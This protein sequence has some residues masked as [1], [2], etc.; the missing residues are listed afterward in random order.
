MD[1]ILQE[2]NA[3]HASKNTVYHCLYGYYFLGLKRNH[4]ARIYKKHPTTIAGWIKKYEQE[5][6]FDRKE[7]SRVFKR[8]GV[9]ER[10]WIIELYNKRPVLLLDEARDLFQREFKKTI[11]AASINRILHDEGYSWKVLERRAIQLRFSDIQR[12]FNELSSIVWDLHALVFL[13]EVS[14]DNRGML[15][16]KGYAPVGKKLIYRGEFVRRPRCSLLSFLGYDGVLETF[17]TEGTFT[18]AKFFDCIRKF[19]TNGSVQT[20][21]GKYSVWIMDGARIHCH[22]SIIDYL[23]SLGIIVLFLPAYAPFYNPIEYVFGYLKKYLKRNYVENDKTDLS[24]IIARA[25]IR[26]KSYDCIRIFR[27]C[28]YLAGGQFD[29][30]IGLNQE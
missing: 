22:K 10:Q 13:D 15:R 5:G 8:F 14:F 12:F 1:T 29:P 9:A 24:V 26:F 16:T 30:S 28:G 7:R 2:I 23:R 27:K 20:H 18:R 4:L 21:P 17:S 19:A 25:L 6:M 11:S 3:K